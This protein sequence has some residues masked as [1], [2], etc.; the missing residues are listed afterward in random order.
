MTRT[1]DPVMM[2]EAS[3]A[4]LNW[5]EEVQDAVNADHSRIAKL[6]EGQT[7]SYDTMKGAIRRALLPTANVMAQHRYHRVGLAVTKMYQ[8]A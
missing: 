3:S 6:K 7:G 1:G 4:V 5:G 8:T 2:V